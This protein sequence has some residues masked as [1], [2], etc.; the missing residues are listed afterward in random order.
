[1]FD[2]FENSNQICFDL[3]GSKES[4]VINSDDLVRKDGHLIHVI[5]S[6]D[7]SLPKE[8]SVNYIDKNTDY[9]IN[10]MRSS[11]ESHLGNVSKTIDFPIVDEC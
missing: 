9:N 11:I 2:V 4:H 1:M 10:N 5:R 7:M 8:I 6:S 3:Q